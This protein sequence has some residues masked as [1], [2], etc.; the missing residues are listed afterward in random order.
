M[1]LSQKDFEKWR[2]HSGANEMQG[3]IHHGTIK[4]IDNIATSKSKAFVS[5]LGIPSENIAGLYSDPSI[6]ESWINREYICIEPDPKVVK[7][8]PRYCHCLQIAKHE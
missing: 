3:L 6:L 4:T 5:V 1:Y 8:M 7:Q 2:R